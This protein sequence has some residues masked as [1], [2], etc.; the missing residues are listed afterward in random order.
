MFPLVILVFLPLRTDGV[1]FGYIGF[2]PLRTGGVSFGYSGFPQ[3][4]F[5]I[6]I[7]AF[8]LA[9]DTKKVIVKVSI[10]I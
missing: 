9:N 3:T 5:K 2:L 6:M 10:Y 7:N 8:L 1:S 4:C